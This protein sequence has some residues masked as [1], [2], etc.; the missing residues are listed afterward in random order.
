MK[1]FLF[2]LLLLA[3]VQA[4]AQDVIVMKDGNTVVSKILEITTTEI[5]YKKFSNLDG[6]TYTVLKSE[7]KGINYANGDKDVFETAPATPATNPGL[8]YSGGGVT[9]TTTTTTAP[10]YTGAYT[11]TPSV[12][13]ELI[14]SEGKIRAFKILGWVGGGIM[15]GTGLALMVAGIANIDAVDSD[16]KYSYGGYKYSSNDLYITYLASGG[17]CVAVGAA[18]TTVFLVCAHRFERQNEEMSLNTVPV[19]QHEFALKNGRALTAGVD[20]LSDRKMHDRTVG[21]GLRYRF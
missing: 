12:P 3:A 9:N 17:A 5:K 21:L 6:P 7:V 13:K 18:W 14:H 11:P 20:Y 1:K 15:V 8:T 16:K 10:V 2:M 4:K 19:I